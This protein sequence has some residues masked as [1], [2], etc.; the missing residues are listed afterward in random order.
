M[1]LKAYIGIVG[2]S[3]AWL[4]TA[5]LLQRQRSGFVV[6]Q[7]DRV[8]ELLQAVAGPPIPSDGPEYAGHEPTAGRGRE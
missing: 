4:V 5:H 8:D 3:R 2:T 1:S 6:D 7:A